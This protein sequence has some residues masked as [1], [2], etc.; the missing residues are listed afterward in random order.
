MLLPE[1]RVKSSE[2]LPVMEEERFN[3]QSHTNLVE[4]SDASATAPTN[5]FDAK[6][7]VVVEEKV[8]PSKSFV[9]RF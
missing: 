1:T 8:S 6:D 4:S 2:S 5:Q 3:S 9:D 7:A